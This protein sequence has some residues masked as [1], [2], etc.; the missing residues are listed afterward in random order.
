MNVL[1]FLRYLYIISYYFCQ[2]IWY[3]LWMTNA[4]SQQQYN[5]AGLTH[6][7]SCSYILVE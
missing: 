5:L 4:L 2:D 3:K 7:V 1:N 6:I